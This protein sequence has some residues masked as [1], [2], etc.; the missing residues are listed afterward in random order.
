MNYKKKKITQLMLII[1]ALT[2]VSSLTL[3]STI[4]LDSKTIGVNNDG[5]PETKNLDLDRLKTSFAADLTGFPI[6][7]DDSD[8]NYNWS[9]TAEDNDWCTSVGDQYYIQNIM[10]NNLGSQ[11]NSVE[12][13][14]SNVEFVIRTSY[15]YNTSTWGDD[16]ESNG[17]FLYN[18]TNGFINNNH[19]SACKTGIRIEHSQNISISSNLVDYNYLQ[20]IEFDSSSNNRLYNNTISDNSNGILLDSSNYNELVENIIIKNNQY[21]EDSGIYFYQSGHNNITENIISLQKYR[22]I[23]MRYSDL[24]NFSG[25]SIFNNGMGILI[26]YSSDGNIFTRNSIYNHTGS[27]EWA[28]PFKGDGILCN[29]GGSNVINNNDIYDNSGSGINMQNIGGFNLTNNNLWSNDLDDI[30]L[31]ETTN[32]KLASN[33][34][35]GTG[36]YMDISYSDLSGIDIDTTNTANGKPIYFY[37]DQDNL[38]S[39]NFSNAGQ[40]YLYYCDH[41][42]L[43][44]LEFPNV[45]TGLTLSHCNDN[46]ISYID[47]SYNSRWGVRLY[48]CF[49]TDL[50]RINVSNSE[51]GIELE[52]CY[53]NDFNDNSASYNIGHGFSLTNCS[54]NNITGNFASYNRENGLDVSGVNYSYVYNNTANYNGNIG[55]GLYNF[56][57]DEGYWNSTLGEWVITFWSCIQDLTFLSNIAIGN[58]GTGIVIDS[59]N[60]SI[61]TE[62]IANNN[63][64]GIQILDTLDCLIYGNKAEKNDLLGIGL[65]E[66]R[67]TD[68]YNNTANENYSFN[69]WGYDPT[70]NGFFITLC[71]SVEVYNNYA[72]KNYAGMVIS[73]STDCDIKENILNNNGEVSR[74]GIIHIGPSDETFG[75]ILVNCKFIDVFENSINYNYI[76]LVGSHNNS[77]ILNDI[78]WGGFFIH[79]SNSNV[80][81]GNLIYRGEIG[82]AL[83]DSSYNQILNNTITSLQCFRETGNCIGNI[84][85]NNYCKEEVPPFFLREIMAIIGIAGVLGLNIPLYLKKRKNR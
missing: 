73:E 55:I 28:D 51:S 36:L 20:G 34:M 22:A 1:C 64:K 21:S 60:N 26:E 3:F 54:N 47:A 75:L 81:L 31:K 33:A 29:S 66:G 72:F 32:F 10:I 18:V 46:A 52:N 61:I 53:S 37:F 85:E 16:D 71:D 70:G 43:S 48:K 63:D 76:Q 2:L 42:T 35:I 45:T 11:N 44:N 83:K 79:A 50:S 4:L 5:Q 6:Y 62:N 78:T 74:E 9:K 80:I 23:R 41:L 27:E 77:L 15:F 57:E 56:G 68:F 14:N 7:I 38:D 59:V 49:N 69:Q 12:I 82:V 13:R 25:N 30:N 17:I 40:I 24:N 65:S 19:F 39:G 84:F 58:N 8:P 67:D